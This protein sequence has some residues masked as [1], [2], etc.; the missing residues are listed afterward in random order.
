MFSTGVNIIP[1]VEPVNLV[2]ISPSEKV[3]VKD[4]V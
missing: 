2:V 1:S 4:L 3:L